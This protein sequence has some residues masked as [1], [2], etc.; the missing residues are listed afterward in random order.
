VIF[1]EGLKQIKLN[2]G[3]KRIALDIGFTKFLYFQ[4]TRHTFVTT[5]TMINETS[6]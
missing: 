1:V 4:H 6:L 3:I 2:N 5:V